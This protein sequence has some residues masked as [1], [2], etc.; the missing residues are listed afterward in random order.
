MEK[1][2][3]TLCQIGI[4][5][6]NSNSHRRTIQKVTGHFGILSL[7]KDNV[8]VSKEG[9]IQGNYSK[10]V[11]LKG[12]ATSS[13]ATSLLKFQFQTGAIKRWVMMTNP[14]MSSRFNSKLVRLEVWAAAS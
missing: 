7:R 13:T 2:R 9:D 14:S 11:R 6:S 8:N 5:K 12:N 1:Y 10:L 4:F 3:A